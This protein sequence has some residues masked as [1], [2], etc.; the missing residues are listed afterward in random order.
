M[1]QEANEETAGASGNGENLIGDRRQ[2]KLA[3]IPFDNMVSSH[4]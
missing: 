2:Q 3:I 1:H 4:W